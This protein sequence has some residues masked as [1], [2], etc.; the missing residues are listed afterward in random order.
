MDIVKAKKFSPAMFAAI[1]I[2]F[3][4][5]F[6]GYF[7]HLVSRECDKRGIKVPFRRKINTLTQLE[8]DGER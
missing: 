8:K 2:T 5:P 6:V 3:F 4:L 7:V 1:V